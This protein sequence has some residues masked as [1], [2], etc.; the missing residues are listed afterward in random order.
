MGVPV[1]AAELNE[2]DRFLPAVRRLGVPTI[3]GD[4]RLPETLDALHVADAPVIV[5]TTTTSSTWRPP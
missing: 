3:V 2:S 1:V 4:V 5:V